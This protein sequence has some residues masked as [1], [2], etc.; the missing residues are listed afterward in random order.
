MRKC[1]HPITTVRHIAICGVDM[2][3]QILCVDCGTATQF[4]R[5]FKAARS[6]WEAGRVMSNP[7]LQRSAE[8][9][10]K[11]RRTPEC[12]TR[13]AKAKKGRR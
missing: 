4:V 6:A 11:S 5:S 9:I 8:L 2:G 12:Q 3:I 10:R 1:R 13:P 7:T